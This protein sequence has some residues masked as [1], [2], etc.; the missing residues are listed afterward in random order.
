MSL[1]DIQRINVIMTINFIYIYIFI[2]IHF[3]KNFNF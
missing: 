2:L 3:K 1:N